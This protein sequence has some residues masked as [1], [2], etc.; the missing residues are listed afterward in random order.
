[1][2]SGL[3]TNFPRSVLTVSMWMRSTDVNSLSTLFSYVQLNDIHE[4]DNISESTS[5][6][7]N[8]RYV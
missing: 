4:G 7:I 2:T 3:M 8:E 6:M 5:G 1:V